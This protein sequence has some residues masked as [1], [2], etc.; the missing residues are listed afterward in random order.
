MSYGMTMR[1][2]QWGGTRAGQAE[3]ALHEAGRIAFNDNGRAY[4]LPGK[5]SER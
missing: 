4:L 3:T 2:L 1:V 5:E